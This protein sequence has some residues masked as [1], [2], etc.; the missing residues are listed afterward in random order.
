MHICDADVYVRFALK[1][2]SQRER[3]SA[4]LEARGSDLVKQGLKL[5]KVI[6]VDQGYVEAGFFELPGYLQAGKAC[7]EDNYLV[8]HGTSMDKM[9]ASNRGGI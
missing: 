2:L 8:S 5:V 9:Y 4:G 1:D 3:Y 7:A 6:L